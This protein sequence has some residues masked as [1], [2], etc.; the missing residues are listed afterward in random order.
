MPLFIAAG[1]QVTA[2]STDG[3]N[4]T[5]QTNWPQGIN[6]ENPIAG[7][8]INA[9]ASNGTLFA[10]V[11]PGQAQVATTTDGINWTL[12]SL[13]GGWNTGNDIAYGNGLWIAVGYTG[14][15]PFPIVSKIQTSPDGVTWTEVIPPDIRHLNGV[16]YNGSLWVVGGSDG[17]ITSL[18]GATWTLQTFTPGFSVYAVAYGNGYFVAVGAG[19]GV[20]T[21]PDGVTWTAQTGAHGTDAINEVAY[22]GSIFVAVGDFNKVSTSPDG[23][24]WTAQT[25]VHDPAQYIETVEFGHGIFVIGAYS[26]IDYPNPISTSPDGITWTA[27]PATNLTEHVLAIASDDYT[28]LGG[29]GGGGEDS[30]SA[31]LSASLQPLV[32]SFSSTFTIYAVTGLVKEQGTPASRVVRV[33]RRDTGAFMG[34]TTSAGDG[35][36]TLYLGNYSGEVYVIAL[37]D[38]GTAPDLNA[39]IKDRVVPVLQ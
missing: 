38:I 13:T 30:F 8:S 16:C 4:W 15:G 18:D 2:T 5:V 9:L 28:E 37:D 33:Y 35:T 29:G 32:T 19:G 12:Y 1:N 22:S 10:A 20:A 26:S 34:E 39:S 23:I 24:N 21:S 27:R 11:M 17:I 7:Y 6:T 36:F 25:G 31:V 3:I 14:G